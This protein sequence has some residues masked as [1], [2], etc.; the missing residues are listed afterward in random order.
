[1]KAQGNPNIQQ[2][3]TGTEKHPSAARPS[4]PLA[5]EPE[6]FTAAET[7]PGTHYKRGWVGPTVG[8]DPL[9]KKRTPLKND[10]Q[11]RTSGYTACFGVDVLSQLS[12]TIEI[13]HT[14]PVHGNYARN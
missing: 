7:A 13:H 5:S 12:V 11:S 4:L 9:R 2:Q 10:V 6:R 3:K 1:M 14:G 8:T